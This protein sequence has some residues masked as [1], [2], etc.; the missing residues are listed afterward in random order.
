MYI[1]QHWFADHP[2]LC[3]CICWPCWTPQDGVTSLHVSAQEGCNEV[4]EILLQ[5][6]AEV[7]AA[8]KVICDEWTD[9][10]QRNAWQ[11]VVEIKVRVGERHWQWQTALSQCSMDVVDEVSWHQFAHPCIWDRLWLMMHI[12]WHVFLVVT[13]VCEL[14][15]EV[16]CVWSIF[17]WRWP[18]PRMGHLRACFLMS[19]E[20][21]I[22]SFIAEFEYGLEVNFLWKQRMSFRAL[23]LP[24]IPCD[25]KFFGAFVHQC[26]V[27]I[28]RASFLE[29]TSKCFIFWHSQCCVCIFLNVKWMGN[30]QILFNNCFLTVFFCVFSCA[31]HVG[32][33]RMAPLLCTYQHK[34][35]AKRW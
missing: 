6:G 29:Q 18:A 16:V 21:W 23:L 20:G 33:L 17:L 12:V 5:N 7:N 25:W 14:P 22:G 11:R 8:D 24:N 31:D 19:S 4:V 27:P 2:L 15:K 1:I 10:I 34:M 30:K 26:V 32:L 28:E 3:V 13:W 9:V 35:G